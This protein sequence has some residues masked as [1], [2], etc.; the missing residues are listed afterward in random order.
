MARPDRR[1]PG[2]VD[3][4]W[5]VD[6]A[7]ID[8]DLARRQAPELIRREGRNSVVVRQPE[9]PDEVAAMWRAAVGCPTASVGQQPPQR[10][11]SDVFP[12]ELTPGVFDLGYAS[13]DSF[14]ATS[15]F[16]PREDG[17][18]LI[19]APRWTN[20][21]VGPL[22]DRGG[23]AHVLL[24][25]R[26]DIADA[27]RYAEHFGARVWIHTADADAAPFATDVV[28]G[29]DDLEL[30]PGVVL[31]PLPGHTRGSVAFVVDE[32]WLFSGDSLYWARGRARLA[33]HVRATWYSA[34]EQGRS[35]DRLA[36]THR[37]TWVLPGHGQHVE[38]DPEE[39]HRDLLGLA[40]RMVAGE[41]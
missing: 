1:H 3:G 34:Q 5:Y 27:Q 6:D 10:R 35:L 23:L 22:E 30:A 38:G 37:F 31:V 13:P 9:T 24:T 7:C 36:R 19:D 18:L 2:N 4:P 26:D 17:N 32:R 12:Y 40:A 16:V 33:Y 14:G 20:A 39:L 29:D 21:L 25:H 15:W 8:C 11:P 41:E 28:D